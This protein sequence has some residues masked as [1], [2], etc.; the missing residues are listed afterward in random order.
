MAI[1]EGKTVAILGRNG[2]GKTTTFRSIMSLTPPMQGKIVYRGEDI[3]NLSTHKVSKKGLS[4]VPENRNIF[5]ALNVMQHLRVPVT[6]GGDR[7]KLLEFVFDL[8][9]VLEERKNQSAPSLSG[10]EQQM[11][12]IGR[13]LMT[14][15][16]LLLLDEPFE[17]L[18]P[19][20][21]SDVM[22]ALEKIKEEG[23]N[24]LLS[25]QNLARALSLSDTFY[26]IEKGKVGWF[27]GKE[28]LESSPEIKNK[29]LG[30]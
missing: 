2:A 19:K 27:G 9:P 11:L 10:G 22:E 24:I 30:I 12:V 23:V 21:V 8:F 7:D 16:D 5:P 17:G 25:S 4:L 3:T 15:P 28:E 20:I 1:K 13:A 29:Y 14:D 6:G 26:I 18:A